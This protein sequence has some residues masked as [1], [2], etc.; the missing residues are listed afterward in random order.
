MKKNKEIWLANTYFSV[1]P[2][3]KLTFELLSVSFQ[4][5]KEPPPPC[6]ETPGF[7]P[8]RFL[9]LSVPLALIV[10]PKLSYRKKAT[11]LIH[12]YGYYKLF[13][14]APEMLTMYFP[15]C[16]AD[17]NLWHITEKND[18][19]KKRFLSSTAHQLKSKS[20]FTPL[21]CICPGLFK[22]L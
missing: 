9:C 21:T 12:A 13:I 22:P 19:P 2:N 5:F 15:C 17:E 16:D 18:L 11:N 7:L 4:A 3:K 10:A 6:P 14:H 20:D 1:A 8:V